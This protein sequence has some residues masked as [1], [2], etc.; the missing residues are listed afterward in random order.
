[1]RARRIWGSAAAAAVALGTA[2]VATPAT[3]AVDQGLVGHWQLDETSGSVAVDSSGNGRDG[4]VSGTA[5][6]NAGDGFTFTGGSAGSGNA[7]ALPNGLLTGL[8]DITI[9]YDVWVD[10][11]LSGFYFIFSLGNAPGSNGEYI[12]M[13]G[14]DWEQRMRAAITAAGSGELNTIRPGAIAT[15]QWRHITYTIDG[16]TTAA[17]GSA[18]LYEDGV[19]VARNDAITVKPSQITN[20]GT[21]N[22]LGRSPWSGDS[23]FKGKIRDFR[24][25][26]RTLT[27]SERTEL[28]ADVA[29][30][31]ATAAA[32]ALTLGD[33]SAVTTNLTLPTTGTQGTTVSWSSSGPAVVSTTGA[34][35][36]PT[37]AQG[38]A[39]VTLTATVTRGSASATHDFVV[40][41][42]ALPD[43]E[44]LLAEDLAAIA[45][46]NLEDARGNLTLPVTGANG[47]TFVWSS[48]DPS[49]VD[50]TGVVTRPAH[51]EPT[52]TVQLTATG[53]HG[54]VTD[55]RTFTATVPALPAALDTDAYVFTYFEGESTADG[56]SIYLGASQGDDPTAWDDLN[57][58][59]PVLTSSFGELGLRDP[60][61]MRSPEGDKFYLLATDL[62]IYPGGSFSTAQQTG[63]TYIEVWE[64]T[65]LVHWS[66]QRHVKVSSDFAG[67]T[68]A[69]EAFYDDDLGAYVVYWASNLYPTTTTAGRS[70]TTTYNRMMYATT[71]DFVTFSE[72]QPWIDVKRGTGLGMIDATVVKDGDT[73]YRF[74][75][76]EGSMTV[77]QERST[78]L[79][80]TVSGTLPTTSSPDSGWQLVKERVGVGQANPWGGTFT[81]G[82]GPTAFQANDG[83]S[84]YLFIDQP[85]Y[86][87]GR[88]YMAFT[89]TDIASG[90]WTSLPDAELPSSPRHGTV[91]P[92]TQAEYDALLTAYQPDLLVESA[93][94]QRVSTAQGVAPTLPA[95]ANVH[96]A[97]GSA[98]STPVAWDAVDPASYA[99][100]GS[101]VVEGVVAAGS[102]V[103]AQVTVVV[104]DDTDP[105]VDLVA[106]EAPDGEAGWYRSAVDVTASATD[107]SG[108]ASV[109]VALDGADWVTTAGDEGA[110]TVAGD[111]V[112]T[113]LARA[114]DTT[115]RTGATPAGL[116]VHVDGTAPVSRATVDADARTVTLRAADST[117]GVARTEYR[118]TGGWTAYT[119][120]VT[121]G[122]AATTVQYRALD[123]AGNTE[124]VNAAVV[125][126][127]GTEPVASKLVAVA[128]ATATYGTYPNVAVSVTGS[129]GV[130]SGKVRVLEGSTVLGSAVLVNGRATVT[131]AKPRVGTHR[132]TV[133]YAGD[134]RFTGSQKALTVKVVKAPTMT[135]V[136]AASPGAGKKATANVRVVA[137]TGVAVTGKV[138]V[139]VTRGTTTVATKVA[140]L[141]S[142]GKVTLTLPALAAGTYTVKIAYAGSG[143][144]TASTGTTR[145]VVRS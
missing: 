98:R 140:T 139:T 31:A 92:V 107:P 61:I 37:A 17:P 128:P 5:A 86:H 60:F 73:F 97:D 12:F 35:T 111:G 50:A 99:A 125:P 16:G 28:A 38:D 24:I 105:L 75:K 63:S 36:R 94:P 48:S 22:I 142:G 4:T 33:T 45:V 101:F 78:D 112:H 41:V 104:T 40:T 44:G 11:D 53:T 80:A 26:D 25:Y 51:G 69:P 67:N 115:G 122:T 54:V 91:L 93:D 49:V 123:V 110:V 131:L 13:N 19:E 68:W 65:D 18:V 34:V 81:Q 133:V 55:T 130:P 108:V 103:R 145:L 42:V 1:M 21:F 132:L 87:N 138:R 9:D 2:F 82:E 10:S 77:R 7:V 84:W 114:T 46:P 66:D 90:T 72:P 58:G 79:L 39:T 96:Y 20:G 109:D 119:G 76:D 127:A 43:D 71:R 74:V 62:K 141:G 116:T 32:A 134:A 23:S 143:T 70:Y 144:V 113:V 56:E 85:S 47:S 57:D 95:T 15:N 137:T 118:T 135:S 106:D 14:W 29:Q 129:G 64:S 8:D 83:D 126:A 121:V 136:T 100:P 27:E 89:T 6:W 59:E 102:A 52:A 124:V 117:S 120:P 30:P 88:G 3:A